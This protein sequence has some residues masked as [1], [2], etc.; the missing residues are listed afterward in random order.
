MAVVASASWAQM[1]DEELVDRSEVIV[2][3]VLVESDI[4]GS[5]GA[6]KVREVLKGEINETLILG[7]RPDLVSSD[8]LFYRVGQTGLWFLRPS[9]DGSAAVYL[10][11][12][13]QRFEPDASTS[14]FWKTLI[15]TRNR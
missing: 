11:D 6:I 5:F 14:E 4:P 10:A 3:G 15:S 8:T 7:G 2:V 13:P 1:S 12:H 9:P